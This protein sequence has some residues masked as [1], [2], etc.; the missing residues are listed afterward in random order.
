VRDERRQL[1]AQRDWSGGDARQGKANDPQSTCPEFVREIGTTPQA[2][3][4]GDH[5]R[6]WTRCA[7]L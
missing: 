6:T 2:N 1:L 4:T 5:I 7:R 3:R